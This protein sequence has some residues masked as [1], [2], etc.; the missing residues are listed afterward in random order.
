MNLSLCPDF[1]TGRVEITFLLLI[2][3]GKG[4]ENLA[5]AL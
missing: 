5:K 1:K 3:G 4:Y 2:A